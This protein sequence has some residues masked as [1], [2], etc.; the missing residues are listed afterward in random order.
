MLIDSRII[1]D[2][3]SSLTKLLNQK[4]DEIGRAANMLWIGFGKQIPSVNFRGEHVL[5]SEYAIHI[6]CNWEIV[7]GEKIILEQNDFYKPKTGISPECFDEEQLGASKFDEIVNSIND[8]IKASPV[9]VINFYVDETGGFQLNLSNSF[10]IKI[11][12]DSPMEGESW[13][14]LMPGS[15]NEHLVIFEDFNSEINDK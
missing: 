6:Q 12:P 13:R 3:S 10:K 7:D 2:I 1:A 4:L 15:T 9:H 14:F 5:K 8:I 11:Y